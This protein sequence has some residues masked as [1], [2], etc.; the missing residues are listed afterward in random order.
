MLENKKEQDQ[1]A[2]IEETTAEIESEVKD[3]PVEKI[4]VPKKQ[5]VK[6]LDGEFPSIFDL[7]KSFLTETILFPKILMQ[8]WNSRKTQE[9]KHSIQAQNHRI[10]GLDK[11]EKTIDLLKTAKAS[12][13]NSV[14]VISEEVSESE[15]LKPVSDRTGTLEQAKAETEPLEIVIE[16]SQ[17]KHENQDLSQEDIGKRKVSEMEIGI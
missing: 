17:N 7:A 14:Y 11:T 3:I 4:S 8:I 2:K 1:L 13:K 10:R 12:I 9:N 16:G 6:G 15:I 5:V